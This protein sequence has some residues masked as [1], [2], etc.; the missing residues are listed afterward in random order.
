MILTSL[1]FEN[2]VKNIQTAGYNGA[3]TVYNIQICVVTKQEKI[4]CSCH[5]HIISIV[6]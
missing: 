3:S 4:D 5:N 1:E 2:G 6:V